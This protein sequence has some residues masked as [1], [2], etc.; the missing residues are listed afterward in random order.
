MKTLDQQRTLKAYSIWSFFLSFGIVSVLA[1]ENAGSSEFETEAIYGICVALFHTIFGIWYFKGNQS[2]VFA[3]RTVTSRLGL[4]SFLLLTA[5]LAQSYPSDAFATPKWID[6]VSVYSLV[7]GVVEWLSAYATQL[8]LKHS[9]LG[10]DSKPPSRMSFEARNRYVFGLYLLLLGAIMLIAPNVLLGFFYLPETLFIGFDSAPILF[11]P[12][13]IVAI[14]LLVLGSF[15]LLAARHQIEPL[16]EAGM[17]G[18]SF[19]VLF[20][21]VLVGLGLLHPIALLLPA[22]D[23][24]S[25]VLIAAHKRQLARS[26]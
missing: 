3:R 11:G 10:A 15:N 20:F 2:P 26:T 14:Q 12:I 22:I 4:G 21:I 7:A 16:I 25:I 9:R 18:G 1:L 8:S 23:I 6:R 19:A 17:R 5:F 13:Q 24:V